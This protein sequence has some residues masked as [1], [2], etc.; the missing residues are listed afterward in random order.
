M[1]ANIAAVDA[2]IM[3]EGSD[4]HFKQAVFCI[5]RSYKIAKKCSAISKE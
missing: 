1:Y 3:L 4:I 5:E 2:V